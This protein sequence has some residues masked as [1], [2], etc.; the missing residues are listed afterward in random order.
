MTQALPTM[1]KD[2][3][4]LEALVRQIEE[5][6]L[7]TGFKVTSNERI[8][9][10]EGIQIAEFDVEVRGKLGTTDIAWLIECR[11]RPGSGPA[12]EVG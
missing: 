7:P 9:N 5:L 2:G 3:K 4:S 6:L 10:D 8:Y 12:P 11:D 1:I